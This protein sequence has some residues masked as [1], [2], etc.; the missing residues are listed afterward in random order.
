MANDRSSEPLSSQVAEHIRS[1]IYAKEWGPGDRLPSEHALM[2]QFGVS[3]G[4]VRR[5]LQSLIQEGLLTS[6]H[7]RGTFV[8]VPRVLH[9]TGNRPLSFAAA[10]EDQGI[11]FETTVLEREAVT[12]P[13]HVATRLDLDGADLVLHSHRLRC[14]SAGTPLMALDSWIPLKRCPGIERLDLTQV[15]LFDAVQQTSGLLIAWSEMS[16]TAVLAGSDIGAVLGVPET[17]PA[18]RLDQLIYLESGDPVEWSSVFLPGGHAI[19]GV[20]VQT[21]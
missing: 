1:K 19:T 4:T 15:S 9:P 16:Y 13:S 21:R 6:E 14:D 12:P 18:L 7:G 17:A 11:R 3:R 20:G 10:L 5:A 2:E 8:R